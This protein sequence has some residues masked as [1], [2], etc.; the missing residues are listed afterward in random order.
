[1]NRHSLA[2]LEFDLVRDAL[3]KRSATPYG[4]GLAAALAPSSS[5]EVVAERQE[6][7][8]EA[9][10]L[11]ESGVRLDLGLEH[12]VRGPLELLRDQGALLE[13]T[14]LL[15]LSRHLF[16]ARQAKSSVT[17]R[18]DEVP[19][20]AR[21]A[22]GLTA[23]KELEERIDRSIE[24][25][26][27]IADRASPEL[28]RVRKEQDVAR[29][30]IR[31]K[32][33]AMIGEHSSSLQENIV[34]LREGR[35][36]IPVRSEAKGRIKGIVHDTSA[37]GATVFVEPLA[38]VELNNRLRE[39]Q[40]AEQ[41]ELERILQ[42]FSA[43]VQ[44]HCDALLRNIDLIGQLDLLFA[45]AQLA[46]DWRCVRPVACATRY[47]RLSQARHPALADP[48]PL[49]IEF[50]D[51]KTLLVITGPNT[52][53]K[54]VVLKT[55]GLL[56]LMH[57]S[58]LQVPAGDGSTLPLFDDVYCDIGDE[59]SIAQSLSTF[60]S[61]VRQV[62]AIL[63]AVTPASLVLLDEVGVGTEPA[64]G[65]ALAIAVLSDLAE[66][67][68]L[69]LS[70]THYGALKAFVQD[71][72]AMRNAAMEFDRANLVP[73]YRLR[74]GVPGSSYGI[75][76]ASR[77]GVPQRVIEAARARIDAKSTE[78]E[79][80]LAQMEQARREME[81][82]QREA[83]EQLDRAERIRGE[84]EGKV[85]GVKEELR[86]L[87]ARAEAEAAEVLARARSAAE[88][89]VAAIKSEQ[90]SKQSIRGA[91][92]LLRDTERAILTPE[93]ESGRQ[94]ERGAF[95][96]GHRF[97]VGDAV[98]VASIGK[99]GVVEVPPDGGG[100]LKV[101]VGGV[102]MS[103]KRGDV[104]MLGPKTFELSAVNVA[105]ADG[106]TSFPMELHLLGYH[107]EE[108]LEKLDQ[109][110]DQAVLLGIG[111]VR[112]VHGKGTGVLR[113]VVKEALA[114]DKRVRSFRLG[115]WNEGQD[116]VTVAELK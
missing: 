85:K 82:K 108:A 79:S 115:E 15:A 59:Q 37:S 99:E 96:P 19:G 60:S 22:G 20:L 76:I 68:P 111:Q 61:H 66:R 33:D 7:T 6:L 112:I 58:G 9:R 65:S 14:A 67:G 3:G 98:F 53:G 1:M 70:T 12:E 73:T 107:A 72:P 2:I 74:L 69:T 29:G 13:P 50:G 36:V 21:L 106:E 55:V 88:L 4:K 27:R 77:L 48:V 78:L 90:A 39:L 31:D 34:T 26:G 97:A 54:T 87:K 89:A 5:A 94:P 35:Y 17:V 16:I 81:Q 42:A 30:R 24:P 38:T 57:Q 109:Y 113:K 83:A 49:D 28:F 8:A 103:L 63:E 104:R 47:L 40:S 51:G 95:D 18:R 45:Q 71:H 84:Y 64:E 86:G 92:E 56:A 46:L 102:R 105:G 25:D 116:G 32:L 91:R 80:L 93:H 62:A 41:H 10:T 44:Q 23:F 110:L 52:G 100:K 114:R 101:Q 11:L 43:E 75:E